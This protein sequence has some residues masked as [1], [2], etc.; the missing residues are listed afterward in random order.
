MEPL[1]G[2]VDVDAALAVGHREPRLGPEEGLVLD[3]ELVLAADDDVAG[4]V[5][6]AVADHEMADDV[7][8]RVVE[9]AVPGG[10]AI[11][12]QRLLLQ[13]A[14]HVDDGLER[15]VLDPDRLDRPPRLL[16]MVGGDDRDRLAEVAHPV[17]R[18]HRLVGELEPVASSCP[19]RPRA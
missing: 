18:E 10:R 4:G 1:G 7:R 6:V 15:L 16:G 2:D 17:D 19:G 14:L 13:G 3:A 9:V 12:M 11:G 8:A 5:R